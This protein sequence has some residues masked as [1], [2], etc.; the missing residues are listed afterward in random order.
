MGH[1]P[2]CTTFMH[3]GSHVNGACMDIIVPA[4]STYGAQGVTGIAWGHLRESD[5]LSEQDVHALPTILEIRTWR[6]LTG[7]SLLWPVGE[8]NATSPRSMAGDMPQK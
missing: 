3:V 4:Q 2:Y 8:R 1:C 5:K 7:S 6:Y